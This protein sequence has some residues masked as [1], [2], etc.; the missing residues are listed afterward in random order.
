MLLN[1]FKGKEVEDMRPKFKYQYTEEIVFFKRDFHLFT[2]RKK[3]NDEWLL[4]AIPV[5]RWDDPKHKEKEP[6]YL[7]R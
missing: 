4:W 6:V 5:K 3:C 1:L 7:G 2:A